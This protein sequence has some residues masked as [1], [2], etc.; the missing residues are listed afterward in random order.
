[1]ARMDTRSGELSAA[2]LQ[3]YSRHL[4]LPEVGLEGQ[5]KLK[6]ASVLLVGAGGL[7]SPLGLYLAAAGVGRLAII[8]DDAVDETNLQR[9]VIHGT[10]MLGRAKT[11]S[12][13]QRIT[14]LN[15]NVEVATYPVRLTAANAAD[16][17]AGYDVIVDGSDNFSTR[18]L[19]NDACVL[20]RKPNVYGSVYRFEGQAS[21]FDASRGPCYR[22]IFPLA[23][24][25]GEIPSC[26]EGGVLGVLPGIIGCIQATETIKLIAGIGEPL[27]GRMLVFD[28]LDMRFRSLKLVKDDACPVCGPNPTITELR[29]E[30]VTCDVPAGANAIGSIRPKA[31]RAKLERREPF[32]L[33]DVREPAEREIA[34]LANTHEIP[35]GDL[36]ARMAEVPRDREIVVYCLTGNRSAKAARLLS[37]AGFA[38]VLNLEG[39][40]RAWTDEV[41]PSLTRY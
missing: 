11:H 32:V 6:A 16:I 14:D 37:D 4:I 38:S 36:A 41:D 33:L 30:Q 39:G 17:I 34:K 25:P 18:Y 28:A 3:R 40:I 22:C 5:R 9:Q 12:A 20:L 27:I 21:V 10:H 1:M 7:G 29:D 31:L 13:A 8:D 15:P 2:E 26:A 35:L 19:V 24:P 23:P